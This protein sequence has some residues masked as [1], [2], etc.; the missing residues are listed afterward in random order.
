MGRSGCYRVKVFVFETKIVV[1]G[2]NFLCVD[3]VVVFR[4]KGCIRIKWLFLGKVFVFGHFGCI[5][6]KFF[7]R[8]RFL[9]LGKL[10][11]IG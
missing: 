6:E 5:P 4:Q 1:L 7:F 3:K 2:Q 9:F 8:G 11:V 10:V